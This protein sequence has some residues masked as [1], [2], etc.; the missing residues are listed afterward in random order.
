MDSRAIPKGGHG[1]LHR[2]HTLG[3]TRVLTHTYI[4]THM[5]VYMYIYIGTYIYIYIHTSRI[6]VLWSDRACGAVSLNLTRIAIRTSCLVAGQFQMGVPASSLL[7]QFALNRETQIVS[8]SWE[9]AST[10]L[11][12]LRPADH[13]H[14]LKSTLWVVGTSYFKGGHKILKRRYYGP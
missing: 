14:E 1:I 7:L 13:T 12:L 3:P 11:L 10:S 9:G 4:Y 6:H 8:S 5:H 2:T